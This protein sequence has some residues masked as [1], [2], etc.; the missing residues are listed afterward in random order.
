VAFVDCPFTGEQLSAVRAVR[1]DVAV[2]HAQHAD[3]HGN[4]LLWGLSGVQ[5]EAVLA[6]A[7]AIATVEEVV[8]ELDPPPHSVVLPAWTIDAVCVA[9]GGSHPSYTAGYSTRDNDFYSA[10]D[11]ISRDRDRFREWMADNL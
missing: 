3:R 1:P 7:T 6:S 11:E 5:K 2:I 10:W 4:V 8:D 9:P